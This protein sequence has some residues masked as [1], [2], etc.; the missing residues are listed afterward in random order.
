MLLTAYFR[1]RHCFVRI[2][3]DCSKLEHVAGGVPRG[4]KTGQLLF[5]I[6]VNDLPASK[7]SILCYDFPNASN[8]E[9][10]YATPE[11]KKNDERKTAFFNRSSLSP[12]DIQNFMG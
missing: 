2:N 3:D 4:S 10:Q 12:I 11:L 7:A 8:Q 9:L 1:I 6:F 5:L